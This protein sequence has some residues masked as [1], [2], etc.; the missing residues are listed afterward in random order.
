MAADFGLDIADL[1]NEALAALVNLGYREGDAIS[2]IKSASAKAAEAGT[3]ASLEKL[4][5]QSLQ[6]LSRGV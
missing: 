1:W 2:A 4:I 6:L 5:M 3:P